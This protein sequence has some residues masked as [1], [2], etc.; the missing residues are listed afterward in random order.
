MILQPGLTAK[1]DWRAGMLH[2]GS[3][4]I[5]CLFFQAFLEKRFQRL[6]SCLCSDKSWGP[7]KVQ[8]LHQSEEA[9]LKACKSLISQIGVDFITREKEHVN[10]VSQE[11]SDRV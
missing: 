5:K 8:L 10:D 3:I 9:S 6:L 7:V 2:Q 4:V 1:A 11:T